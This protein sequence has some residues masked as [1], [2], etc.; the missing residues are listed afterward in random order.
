MVKIQI[1]VLDKSLTYDEAKQLYIE[2]RKIFENE[3][4]LFTYPQ[5][6]SLGVRTAP[7]VPYKVTCNAIL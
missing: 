6:P 2:L 4:P 1:E 3:A 5:G 7:I